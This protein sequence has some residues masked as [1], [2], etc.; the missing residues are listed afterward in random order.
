MFLLCLL[1]NLFLSPISAGY[2]VPF[3]EVKKNAENIILR[4][5]DKVQVS[6]VEFKTSCEQ[7]I[8]HVVDNLGKNAVRKQSIKDPATDEDIKHTLYVDQEGNRGIET[9]E[10]RVFEASMDLLKRMPIEYWGER[11][12]EKVNVYELSDHH[13]AKGTGYDELSSGVRISVLTLAFELSDYNAKGLLPGYYLDYF[14]V[15]FYKAL[16]LS[17]SMILGNYEDIVDVSGGTSVRRVLFKTY[18]NKLIC[19]MIAYYSR[20]VL[21]GDRVLVDA[22]W[23]DMSS[24]GRLYSRRDMDFEKYFG[25]IELNR[26]NVTPGTANKLGT[27]DL[28]DAINTASGRY[29]FDTKG[30]DMTLKGQ[31]KMD[32]LSKLDKHE[33]LI[34]KNNKFNVL[35]KINDYL[36]EELNGLSVDNSIDNLA[37]YFV[38]VLNGR[39]GDKEDLLLFGEYTE[40]GRSG[41]VF[42][43]IKTIDKPELV[44]LFSVLVSANGL[45][46]NRD[47]RISVESG[48]KM[49][50]IMS[51]FGDVKQNSLSLEIIENGLNMKFSPLAIERFN[52]GVE[53]LS[54]RVR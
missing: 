35:D 48:L 31:V 11:L 42:D 54:T 27:E 53:A 24:Q 28:M 37:W 49:A 34:I 10:V 2:L 1:C 7:L 36:P 14:I 6:P 43:K 5:Q 30:I 29:Y 23:K 19:D 51:R 52:R 13:K 40:G 17:F 44:G 45:C 33:K 26:V 21:L 50:G 3:E 22:L 16:K 39:L 47:I 32:V 15:H 41:G 25:D 18:F 46:D 38:N 4:T 8:E 20:A 12:L 9:K